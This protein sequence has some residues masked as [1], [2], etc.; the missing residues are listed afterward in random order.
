MAE[1]FLA[2]SDFQRSSVA[3]HIAFLD[4]GSAPQFA[5]VSRLY[6]SMYDPRQVSKQSFYTVL[7]VPPSATLGEIKQSYR[8]LVKK[9]HPGRFERRILGVLL[10][11]NFTYMI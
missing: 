1:S 11:F 9:Y 2:A 10:L 3:Q 7:G 5:R 4:L 8:R 6:V